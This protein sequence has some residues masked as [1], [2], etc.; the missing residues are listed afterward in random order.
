MDSQ[1]TDKMRFKKFREEAKI[2]CCKDN[3]VSN[4]SFMATF[5]E[6][7]HNSVFFFFFF[8]SKFPLDVLPSFHI[9]T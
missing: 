8:N 4:A 2:L 3:N 9:C 1:L 5:A 7:V 6:K